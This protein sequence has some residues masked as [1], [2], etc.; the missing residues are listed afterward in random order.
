MLIQLTNA[1]AALLD[2]QAGPITLSTF[3]LGSASGYI[4][5]PTDTDIH[6]TLIYTGGISPYVV[7]NA[8]IVRYS[9]YLDY[10]L[11]P[12]QF[13]ELGLFTDTGVLFALAVNDVLIDKIKGGDTGNS[14]RL[15]SYLS[16]VQQNYQMWLD[17]ASTSNKFAMAVLGSVDQLPPPQNA[18]PN[19]YI[20]SGRTAQQSGFIAYTDR[21]GLWNFDAYQ[22]AN[23]AQLDIIAF[24]SQSVTIDIS[25]YQTG[26]DPEYIGEIIVEFSTGALYGIC[27][28]VS[29][30]VENGSNVTFGFENALMQTPIVGDKFIIFGRQ[31]LSTTLTNIPIATT[32]DL[33]GIIVGDT[34]TITPQG[35]LNVGPL[36]YP[37]TSVNGQTGTVTINADNLPGLAQVAKTNNYNDLS[38]KPGIASTTALG[39]VRVPDPTK[40]TIVINGLGVIDLGFAPV[41]TVNNQGPDADGN[42][43]LTSTTTGLV[44]AT[45]IPNASDLNTYINTGLFYALAADVNSI[46]NIPTTNIGQFTL[47]VVPFYAGAGPGEVIQRLTTNSQVFFRA[48]ITSVWYPWT[49]LPTTMQFSEETILATAVAQSTFITSNPYTPGGIEVYLAGVRLQPGIDYTATDGNTIILQT[50][51]ANQVQIGATLT[52]SKFNAFNIANTLTASQ[53]A[54]PNGAT[55]VGFGSSTVGTVL[56]SL[57]NGQSPGN[58]TSLAITGISYQIPTDGFNITLTDDGIT[59]L[60]PAGILTSGTITL[61]GSPRAGQK[62]TIVSTQNITSLTINPNTGQTVS[63]AP[64][65]LTAGNSVSFVYHTNTS[66]WYKI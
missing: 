50:A 17:Y 27:R 37:V 34:L 16:M 39:L 63:N 33:G 25:Q 56:T 14:I 65:S 20:I 46:N 18:V 53:L 36:N 19:A 26:M 60:E 22:Y 5:S 3:K 47:E 1:G 4:P 42:I 6:G 23:Q 54:G 66:K 43:N 49:S 51:V 62:V 57:Q 32:T 11:G 59:I 2:A 58:F 21:N 52:V 61:Y 45:Q 38:N 15:D 40:N 8:N 48:Y 64:T 13:G 24:D 28:Y 29:T 12:F 7:I 10:D 44:S 9:C 30:V 31:A 41:K 35:V 55:L